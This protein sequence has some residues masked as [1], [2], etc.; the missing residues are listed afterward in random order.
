MICRSDPGL[1]GCGGGGAVAMAMAVAV[2]VAV[3][4][5]VSVAG[6]LRFMVVNDTG[7]VCPAVV[8][9]LSFNVDIFELDEV[10]EHRDT[11]LCEALLLTWSLVR[12]LDGLLL[13]V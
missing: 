5:A 2:A 9:R 13:V 4:L 6:A 10:T 12:D 11:F 8:L 3:A 1:G 7:A